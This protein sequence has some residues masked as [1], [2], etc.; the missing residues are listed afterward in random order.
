MPRL[1]AS[2]QLKPG[3]P[4]SLTTVATAA[5]ASNAPTSVRSLALSLIRRDPRAQPRERMSDATID[6]YR[7]ELGRGAVFPP[8]VVFF[9][10][11]TH[12]LADGFHRLAAA[13][14]AELPEFLAEVRPGTLRDAILFSVGANASHGLRRTNED[15]R[16]AVITL[17][18]DQEWS[19][20]S[21][22]WIGQ[23]AAV[24]HD[25]VGRL[26]AELGARVETTGR[27]AKETVDPRLAETASD[28]RG[29]ARREALA[30][31]ASESVPVVRQGRDGRTIRTGKI[32]RSVPKAPPSTASKATAGDLA[33]A[34]AT[35]T[36]GAGKLRA[37]D[38]QWLAG[39][40]EPVVTE[41]R[42]RLR[43]QG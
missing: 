20:R 18:Q 5:P 17:L 40:L 28:Q 11:E 37:P 4:V 33:K 15:K 16:R 31:S 32:G 19:G 6:E 2:G 9:D 42:R 39:A 29:R 8:V 13:D 21:D 36:K 10:G 27:A 7:A 22:R 43:G 1:I 38:R 35:L 24:H 41:L 14:R 26:R 12:W 25:T 34:L 30:D 23:Q 3:Q